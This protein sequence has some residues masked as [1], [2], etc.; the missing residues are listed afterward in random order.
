MSGICGIIYFDDKPVADELEGMTQRISHRGLDGITYYRN[1]QVGLAHLMRQVTYESIHE[2]QPLKNQF[3]CVCVAD[4]R[5][6][7]RN[8]LIAQLDLKPSYCPVIT[9]SELILAAYERWGDDCLYHLIGDFAFAIWDPRRQKLVA[10]RDHS[11]IRPFHYYFKPGKFV[12]FASEIQ[13]LFA[14]PEVPKKINDEKIVPYVLWLTD[15]RAHQASTFYQDIFNLKPAHWLVADSSGVATKFC[16]D[17]N[18]ERFSHLKTDEDFVAAHRE[19]FNEA[20]N[21]RIRT[22]FGVGGDISGG[23]DS[24]SIACAALHTLQER[25]QPYWGYSWDCSNDKDADEREF[26]DIMVGVKGLNHQYI[27]PTQVKEMAVEG[28]YNNRPDYFISDAN[29][30]LPTMKAANKNGVRTYLTGVEGDTVLSYGKE[31]FSALLMEGK[32][33]AFR[34]HIE[35]ILYTGTFRENVPKYDR[36]FKSQAAFIAFPYIYKVLIRALRM[37]HFWA[38][39]RHIKQSKR[40]F[41]IP[42]SLVYVYIGQ[43]IYTKLL[44]IKNRHWNKETFFSI[45]HDR[46]NEQSPIL[47]KEFH[48][49]D[50]PRENNA[51]VI[52]HFKQATCGGIIDVLGSYHTIGILNGIDMAHPF[53]DKRLIE[54]SLIVPN[55][56]Q[57]GDGITRKVHRLAV[58]GQVPDA[59]RWRLDKANFTPYM[60]R[61]FY[62][63]FTDPKAFIQENRDL[64]SPYVNVDLSLKY[65]EYARTA[66]LNSKK[67][68]DA[69]YR[70]VR[71]VYL[72]I[73][74]NQNQINNKTT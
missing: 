54:F 30:Y 47:L 36:N 62:E 34:A 10:A 61:C 63:T 7:N 72:A 15:F 69:F 26:I 56:L 49:E 71:V 64:L 24:S 52:A 23:L 66:D 73:W 20:V 29:H 6:D 46:Y 25:Q 17:L 67:G 45:L 4:A 50:I 70:A 53:M 43:K 74:L 58:N 18:L 37:G 38:F 40:Y 31:T 16:W 32:W 41:N 21:C 14:I 19:I 59:I 60:R 1:R 35:H 51:D 44:N 2:K 48:F 22:S 57:F 68:Y 55:H 33:D 3:G 65:A 12:A 42:P 13:A 28:Y 39:L 27:R 9:D 11:G 8:E 5:I